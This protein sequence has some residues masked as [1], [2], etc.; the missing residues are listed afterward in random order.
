MWEVCGIK[1]ER[2]RACYLF[3][4]MCKKTLE[5][6]IFLVKHSVPPKFSTVKFSG[7]STTESLRTQD[8]KDIIC[9]GDKA[10]IWKRLKVRIQAKNWSFY[11]KIR[12]IAKNLT[13]LYFWS[14][15]LETNKTWSPNIGVHVNSFPSDRTKNKKVLVFASPNL[16]REK[17]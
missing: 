10:S 13:I 14:D 6:V 16:R 4:C 15:C 7:A 5:K 1:I 17:S 3:L 2:T 9:L 12:G 8:S 11:K